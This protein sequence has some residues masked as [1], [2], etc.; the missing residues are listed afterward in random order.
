MFSKSCEYGIKSVIYIAQ[1]SSELN[2]VNVGLISKGIN[3]PEF[4]IAKILQDL[5]KKRFINSLKGPKGG[6]FITEEQRKLPI[7]E[8]VK[9]IDGDDIFSKCVLGLENC[10]NLN[11]CPMH[12]EY[13]NIR[14]DTINML[15]NNSIQDFCSLI[16]KNKAVLI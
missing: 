16:N 14:K 5:S 15:E 9:I 3:A 8:L 10:S 7:M 2:P 13:Q 12:N 4:F 11:P 6:F 1:H